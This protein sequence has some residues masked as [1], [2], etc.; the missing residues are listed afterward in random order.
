MHDDV[1]E[2]HEDPF[3]FALAFLA[4]YIVYELG[5]TYHVAPWWSAAL[6]VPL[7]FVI[8]AAQHWLFDRFKVKIG[9]AHV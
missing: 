5:T 4:A 7:M 1:P 2:I 8:G 3:A 6:V 9:R